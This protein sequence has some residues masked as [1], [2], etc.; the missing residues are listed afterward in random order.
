[1]KYRGGGYLVLGIFFAS[2]FVFM[3]KNYLKDH[4]YSTIK[5]VEIVRRKIP[6]YPSFLGARQNIYDCCSVLHI[7]HTIQ[8]F[9]ET[10]CNSTAVAAAAAQ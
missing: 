8:I 9:I 4:I 5:K 10:A 6:R 2:I 7:S 1:M 3:N